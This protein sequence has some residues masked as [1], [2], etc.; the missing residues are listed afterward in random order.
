MSARNIKRFLNVV[1]KDHKNGDRSNSNNSNRHAHVL[2]IKLEN[3][4]V[5]GDESI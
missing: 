5:Q 2:I 4:R 1:H 3:Q